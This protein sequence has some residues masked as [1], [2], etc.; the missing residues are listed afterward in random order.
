MQRLHQGQECTRVL[1]L[2]SAGAADAAG[3]HRQ[4]AREMTSALSLTPT[5]TPT[6]DDEAQ[7]PP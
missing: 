2:Y 7:P 4:M 3:T 6:H 1:L 5:L